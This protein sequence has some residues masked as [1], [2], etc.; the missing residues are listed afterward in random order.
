MDQEL[1]LKMFAALFAIMSPIA[2]L[3]VFLSLTAD[4]GPSFERKVAF[5][6]TD[7]D[8][9]FV[10]MDA[11]LPVEIH[12]HRPDTSNNSWQAAETHSAGFMAS[13]RCLPE[14]SFKQIPAL[15]V[16]GSSRV[17]IGESE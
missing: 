3:P 5:G 16:S 1:F 14:P 15:T 10:E 8:D 11:G 9:A 7:T 17:V 2:N 6:L 4:G 12:F 13:A